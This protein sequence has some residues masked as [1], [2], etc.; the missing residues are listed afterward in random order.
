MKLAQYLYD[1]A[2]KLKQPQ[3]KFAKDF[4]KNQY[5]FA[6]L[7]NNN[8]SSR[9]DIEKLVGKGNLDMMQDN[10]RNLFRFMSSMFLE[11]DPKVLVN[12]LLWVFRAYRAHGF[13]I[14]FWSA[15]VDTI[16][17]ILSKELSEEAKKEILPFFDWII[18]NIP[19]FVDIT[20]KQLKEDSKEIS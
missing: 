11:Y 6:E 1:S 5:K 16:A 12:T 20:D 15:N 4:E 13:K 9:K 8:M 2:E 3:K 19:K 18:I 14:I 10:S 17:E 7:L